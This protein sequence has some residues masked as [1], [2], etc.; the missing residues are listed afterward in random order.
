MLETENVLVLQYWWRSISAT[1]SAETSEVVGDA[2]LQRLGLIPRLDH[3]N[4]STIYEAERN[5][6]AFTL[7]VSS[8]LL[9]GRTRDV[10]HL[11]QATT[12][13]SRKEKNKCKNI[14]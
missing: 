2:E 11:T 5:F 13:N 7:W 6:F 10:Q 4:E 14:R 1:V 3:G 8:A 9:F 12:S